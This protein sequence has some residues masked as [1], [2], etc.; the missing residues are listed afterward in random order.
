MTNGSVGQ[1]CHSG[2]RKPA[3]D[4]YQP[5]K[6][7]GGTCSTF[8]AEFRPREVGLHTISVDYNGLPVTGTPFVCIIDHD[9]RY[10]HL[11]HQRPLSSAPALLLPQY[12]RP[13]TRA[14]RLF[15]PT[16]HSSP[17]SRT[18]TTAPRLP[19]ASQSIPPFQNY[20]WLFVSFIFLWQK[21]HDRR[22]PD[23]PEHA[24]HRPGHG[25]GSKFRS[26][27]FR[28]LTDPK[29]AWLLPT[30]EPEQCKVVEPTFCPSKVWKEE[31]SCIFSQS[32]YV[33]FVCFYLLL[34]LT[35]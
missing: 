22:L 27:H 20:H 8:T 12:D 19:Q 17:S 35:K 2:E 13:A 6:N 23:L 30:K 7:S 4:I 31:L 10:P 9:L 25:R 24:H 32:I 21:Q 1:P 15:C 14:V 34:S 18:I 29:G 3:G 28:D 26:R 11:R 33:Y 5:V 16:S